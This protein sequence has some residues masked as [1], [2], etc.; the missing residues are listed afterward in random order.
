MVHSTSF[1][2]EIPSKLLTQANHQDICSLHKHLPSL[3]CSVVVNSLWPLDC[4]LP[5][6]LLCPWTF[7]GRDTG[8]NSH[9]FLQG[10]LPTQGSNLHLL[11]YLHCS[12]ILYQLIHQGSPHKHLLSIYCVCSNILGVGN[13]WT[14]SIREQKLV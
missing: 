8:M 14:H 13:S 12:W 2:F 1:W 10:F 6:K 5:T 4:T 7:S 3:T 11:Y 9:F